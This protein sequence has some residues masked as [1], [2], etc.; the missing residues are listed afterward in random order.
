M[1][2]RMRPSDA[3]LAL[4]P[5]ALLIAMG[6]AG[7]IGVLDWVVEKEDLFLIDEPLLELLAQQRSPELDTLFNAVSLVFGPAVLPVVVA[8]IALVWWRVS[9][10]WWEPALLVVAM[11]LSTG[12][13]VALKSLVGRDR[14]AD[15][16]MVVPG[17]E[18]SGSFPSGHTV[19]AATLVLVVGYLLWHEDAE[20]SWALTGWVAASLLII[21]GVG[22]SRLYLGYHFLTD[23]LAGLCVALAVLGVV[24]GAERW[25]D[26][27][28]ERRDPPARPTAL[29]VTE[30]D[31][32]WARDG[33]DDAEDG[34]PRRPTGAEAR[35]CAGQK[36]PETKVP[37]EVGCAG[38]HRGRPS[39]GRL[40]RSRR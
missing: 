40:R 34:A 6:V 11:L 23:V 26:L 24:V 4:W 38:G 18:T 14:P 32:A 7:F 10:S 2:R 22:A 29:A 5:A 36:G 35:P 16:L 12:L 27:W 9:R 13:T 3:A 33:A 39:R 20:A 8:A 31:L 37:R 28:L 19:G 17:G 25:R 15:L 21:V 30:E 1:T